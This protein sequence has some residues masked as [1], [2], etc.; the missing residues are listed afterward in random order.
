M[1]LGDISSITQIISVIFPLIAAIYGVY[2]KIEK[3]Q[4]TVDG[5]IGLIKQ[6]L[7]F[8][9]SQFGPNGGG[10]RQAVNEIGDKV[11]KIEERQIEIG[12]KVAELDGKFKQH[13]LENNSKTIN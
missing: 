1:S 6:R 12:D 11:C 10:L 3:R 2:R 13:I 7:D 8:I 5:E 9:I 4:N